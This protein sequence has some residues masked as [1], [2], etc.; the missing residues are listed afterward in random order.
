MNRPGLPV[1]LEDS[2]TGYV[3]SMWQKDVQLA[4]RKNS[5][6][7]GKKKRGKKELLVQPGNILPRIAHPRSPR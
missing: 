6:F 5:F 7:E 2:R 1:G 4:E 3:L